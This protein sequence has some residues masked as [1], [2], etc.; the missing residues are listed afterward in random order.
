MTSEEIIGPSGK[1]VPR[2]K[3]LARYGSDMTTELQVKYD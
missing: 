2:Q 3:Y 1:L